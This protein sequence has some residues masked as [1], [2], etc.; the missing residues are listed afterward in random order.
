L[1]SSRPETCLRL[2]RA[3]ALLASATGA[4][5][6][7][8]W[9]I[10]VELLKSVVPG[11]VGM[12]V[13]TGLCLIAAG[14]ALWLLVGQP[15]RPAVRVAQALAVAV[16]LVSAAVL[17]QY[18]TGRDLG[19]DQAL[20]HEQL[21]AA[22]TVHPNRMAPNTAVAFMLIGTALLFRDV[23]IRGRWGLAPALAALT[24]ALALGSLTGYVAGITSLYGLHGVTQMA[25]PTTVALLALAMGVLLAHPDREPLRSILSDT[26]GGA[27]LRR[28][29]P[30][31]VFMPIAL[32]AARLA[33]QEAGLPTS[34]GMW[35]FAMAI[36]VLALPH[37]WR[38]ARS[39]DRA[40]ADRRE[41]DRLRESEERA[42]AVVDT[43]YDAFVAIDTDA[44]ITGWNQAAER[45]F[46]Y[47]VAE[48]LGRDIVYT[49]VPPRLRA[50]HRR[51]LFAALARADG[52]TS[53]PRRPMETVAQHRSGREI[54]VEFIVAA[55]P[56]P[57]GV[58]FNAFLRDVTERS[59]AHAKLEAAQHDAL[60]RLAIAAEY[61]DDD[62]GDHTRRVGDLAAR[63][64]ER[65]GLPAAEV[66]LLR[67][68]AA[69]HDVGKIGI[70]DTILLKP[71]KLTD[72]EF[73]QVKAHTQIGANMLAGGGFPLLEMAEQIAL[74]HHERWDGGG[75][76]N[77]A[78]R[79]AIPLVGRIVALADVFDA[80]THDRP[81]KEAWSVE[82]AV[83][84]IR[85]QRG[86][87]FD[88]VLTDAFL[89]LVDRQLELPT[90]TVPQAGAF[91]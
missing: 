80:L 50:E 55:S 40:D 22:A 76:P 59:R 9:I 82:A 77:G 87:Q 42:R 28:L 70:P 15:K 8:G 18:L 10:D 21:G 56:E 12:K 14:S 44:R 86:R 72:A 78:A 17:S 52:S 67:S 83:R 16:S 39:L 26:P 90:L 81:Y 91:A 34:E 43:A 41:A 68:A 89:S 2:A 47:T 62:T 6:L 73:E 46:G 84:E 60:H 30:A 58:V 25:V 4:V 54:P 57:A 19:I 88:P 64:G 31:V 3:G 37:V 7:V 36:T 24:A 20:L 48:A 1:T 27:A 74:T 45:L 85:S 23:R 29:V 61:R 75:Y 33:G 71:G 32:G 49:I 69:L 63:L 5:A 66:E 51:V 11:Q 79:E 35:L 38:L 53:L 13:N 65:I